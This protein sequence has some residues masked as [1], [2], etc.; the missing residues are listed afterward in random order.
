MKDWISKDGTSSLKLPGGISVGMYTND[1][2]NV[3]STA[4]VE[5]I[6]KGD[7]GYPKLVRQIFDFWR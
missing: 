5:C 6:G 3:L 7:H 1:M 2:M 4:T